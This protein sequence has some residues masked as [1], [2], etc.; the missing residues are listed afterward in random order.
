MME[1]GM[2][3]ATDNA[4]RTLEQDQKNSP[5]VAF[6]DDQPSAL[7]PGQRFVEVVQRVMKMHEG[8]PRSSGPR[9]LAGDATPFSDRPATSDTAT[10]GFGNGATNTA[11]VTE[12]STGAAP[13]T[14]VGASGTGTATG[15]LQDK[16]VHSDGGQRNQ[17]RYTS[18]DVDY[19]KK[20]GPDAYGQ[21]LSKNARVWSVYND[22]AQIADEAMIKELNGTLDVLL[23]FVRVNLLCAA[24]C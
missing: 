5:R 16:S 10:A 8:V 2:A 21:E 24:T 4:T 1:N 13:V 12:D 15:G 9:D 18:S 22:E 3:A 7:R 14:N 20:Y 11:P 19:E 17:P 23:V 6:V